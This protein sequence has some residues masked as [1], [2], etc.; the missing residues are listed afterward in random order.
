VRTLKLGY[1]K[2]PTVIRGSADYKVLVVKNSTTYNPGDMLQ[3]AE[4]D[5]LCHSTSW[6]VTIV[7]L[8]EEVAS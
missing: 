4:V 5:N 8:K 1:A 7:T 3:K 2:P 6:D